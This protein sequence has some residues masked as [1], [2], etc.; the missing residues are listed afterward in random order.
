MLGPIPSTWAFCVA[1]KLPHLQLL[2]IESDESERLFSIKSDENE[3]LFLVRA[4]SS[5]DTRRTCPV[6][7]RPVTLWA[8][9]HQK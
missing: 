1:P 2:E 4:G 9:R 7:S 5:H 8:L 6:Q 3:A